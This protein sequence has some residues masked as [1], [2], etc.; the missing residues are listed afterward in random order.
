MIITKIRLIKYIGIQ[1]NCIS[2]DFNPH[3]SS[4]AIKASL[5]DLIEAM[6]KAEARPL[7]SMVSKEEWL[8]KRGLPPERRGGRRGGGNHDK[9]HGKASTAASAS[10]G[11]SKATVPSTVPELPNAY[12]ERDEDLLQLK[13]ALLAKDGECGT[14]LTSKKP[15]N[16][17]GAHGMVST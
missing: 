2:V 16:K 5:L 9:E 12:L 3:G 15:Q 13:V 11:S 4:N 10:G 8:R 1:V 7:S 6:E 17:V 14:A